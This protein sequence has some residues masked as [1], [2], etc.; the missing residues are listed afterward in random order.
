MRILEE[1]EQSPE[2]ETVLKICR[3]IPA[4]ASLS[5]AD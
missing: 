5:D 3:D 2:K 1:E 4:F